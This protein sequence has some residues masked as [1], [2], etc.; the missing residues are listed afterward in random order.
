MELRPLL[1]DRFYFKL[2]IYAIATPD[3][4]KNKFI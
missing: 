1:A 2:V 4:I 3:E